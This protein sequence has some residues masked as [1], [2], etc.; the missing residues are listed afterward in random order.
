MCGIIG[1]G[2]TK[3]V[4]NRNWLASCRDTMTHRGP[5]DFGEWWSEDGR[6]GLGH[7]RLS[8]LDL[9]PTGQQP[10]R[11]PELGL[12]IVFNGEIYNYR[13]LKKEL[14]GN[15]DEWAGG[16]GRCQQV[17]GRGPWAD[18]LGIQLT[19]NSQMRTSHYL[20]TDGG[21]HQIPRCCWR[22]MRNGGRTA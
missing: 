22:R 13:E 14:S 20:A 1:I 5:N 16:R 11:I 15:L 3:P 19:A 12:T 2:S 17:V 6:V 21:E 4:E 8:I 7:R 10:M 9:S 18:R